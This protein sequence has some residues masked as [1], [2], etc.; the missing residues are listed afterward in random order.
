MADL[1]IVG[2]GKMGEALAAGLISSGWDEQ[3]Q[4]DITVVEPLE[5]RR[6]E[7]QEIYPNIRVRSTLEK[8]KDILLA[9]KPDQVQTVCHQLSLIGIPNRLI[10]IAAGV[11]IRTLESSLLPETHVIRVMPNTPSMINEGM[12]VLSP[13][14]HASSTD[15]EWAVSIFSAVGKTTVLDEKLMNAVTGVSGSGPAYVFA[16]AE[17][18]TKAGIN[19][20][21]DHESADLL[22][23][24][25]ILGAASLLAQSEETPEQLRNAVTSPNGTT[26]AALAVFADEAFLE[27]VVKAISA[28]THRA[29]QLGT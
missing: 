20:G 29:G 16:L 19:E 17:A 9:V 28:A 24:Q 1:M 14:S 3:N 25:T 7:L 27:V 23:R 2:G 22:V 18:M 11:T 4:G 26:A 21:L 10:S 8:K 12:S 13:G 5:E 15:M 6:A